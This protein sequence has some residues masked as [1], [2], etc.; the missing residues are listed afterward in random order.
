MSS[1]V[2]NPEAEEVVDTFA[3]SAEEQNENKASDDS[4]PEHFPLHVPASDDIL[5]ES[6]SIRADE[7]SGPTNKPKSDNIV[8]ESTAARPSEDED[9][10]APPASFFES[11]AVQRII[12]T[13]N[14][15]VAIYSAVMAALLSLF[16]PQHCCPD[17]GLS[18]LCIRRLSSDSNMIFRTLT[19][20]LVPATMKRQARLQVFCNC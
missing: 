14:V 12:I 18:C 10:V 15:L 19:R 8:K 11:D 9:D 6:S 4:T 13:I 1:I 16:V 20:Y 5:K 17:V 3:K 2:S 7:R